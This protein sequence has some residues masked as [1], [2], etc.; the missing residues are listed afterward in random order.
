L[1]KTRA[2]NTSKTTM[3]YREEIRKI[4]KN[5]GLYGFTRGYSGMLL[6]DAP[7]FASYFLL[8]EFFKHQTGASRREE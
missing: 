3:L 2:Q 1:L 6:R 4:Y 7:G 5:E 8:F